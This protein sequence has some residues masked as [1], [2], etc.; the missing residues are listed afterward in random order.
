MSQSSNES[1]LEIESVSMKYDW[2]PEMRGVYKLVFD[3][4]YTNQI[5]EK[6]EDVKLSRY[7][8]NL[9]RYNYL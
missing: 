8:T 7:F 4:D 2:V 5:A 9:L 1:E 6:N 3:A